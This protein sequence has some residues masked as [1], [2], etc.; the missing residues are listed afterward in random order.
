MAKISRVKVT[1]SVSETDETEDLEIE[2]PEAPVAPRKVTRKVVQA[3]W[4]AP[5]EERRE[6]VKAPNLILKDKGKRIIKILDEQPPVKYKRHYLKSTRRYYTCLQV[7]CPLCAEGVRAG[8]TFMLNVIDMTD[9]PSEVKA[10]TFG[11]EVATQL[12]SHAEDRDLTDPKWYFHVYHEKIANRDAPGTRVLPLKARDVEE[13]YGIQ[14]LTI[15]ELAALDN[16][17]LYGEEIVFLSSA[18][19]LEE[20]AAGVVET[21]KM[22]KHK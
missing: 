14:A 19:Y 3:G 13:D 15:D 17:E 16:D 4:G 5:A 1:D 20:I 21:D 12:Q 18:S 2:E 7:E 11:N 22:P 6:T 9:D 8:W 10:W